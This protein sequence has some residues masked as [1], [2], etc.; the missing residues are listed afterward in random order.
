MSDQV[1]DDLGIGLALK[2]KAKRLQ[3]RAELGVVLDHA[4]MNDGDRALAA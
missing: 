4:V 2:I 3:L 1:G